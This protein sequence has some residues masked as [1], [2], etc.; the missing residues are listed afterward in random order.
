MPWVRPHYPPSI[1]HLLTGN[2]ASQPRPAL[3]QCCLGQYGRDTTM[4]KE[5]GFD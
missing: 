5:K 4:E 3:R 1:M 2:P